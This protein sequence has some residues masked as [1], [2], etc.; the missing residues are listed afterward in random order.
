MFLSLS[1]SL[2]PSL[3][4]SLSPSLPMSLSLSLFS[5]SSGGPGQWETGKFGRP[6][7]L[8]PVAL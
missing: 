3:P 8:E 5:S 1:L 6:I 4:L 7:D 2:S